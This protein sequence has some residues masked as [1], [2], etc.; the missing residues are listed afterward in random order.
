MLLTTIALAMDLEPVRIMPL[1]QLYVVVVGFIVGTA[2][3]DSSA[4]ACGSVLP[5]VPGYSRGHRLEQ[6]SLRAI[7]VRITIAEKGVMRSVEKTCLML[8]DLPHMLCPKYG[9]LLGFRDVC[10]S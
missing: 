3:S 5:A 10:N 1:G 8:L 2:S 4:V 6:A 7:G 9:A